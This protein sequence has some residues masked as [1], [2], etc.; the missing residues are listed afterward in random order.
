M[1]PAGLLKRVPPALRPRIFCYHGERT[2]RFSARLVGDERSRRS[3]SRV[4]EPVEGEAILKVRTYLDVSVST[5]DPSG[6]AEENR[7]K[8]VFSVVCTVTVSL[9]GETLR[10]LRRAD[11]RRA[12]RK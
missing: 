3:R 9:P 12:I 8:A 10:S 6:S 5:I 2:K 4:L 1:N 11:L 7:C